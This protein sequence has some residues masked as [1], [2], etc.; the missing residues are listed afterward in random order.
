LKVVEQL[1]QA[2]RRLFASRHVALARRVHDLE[3]KLMHPI[4]IFRRDTIFGHSLVL[5]GPFQI[6][7]S[8]HD[9]RNT[10]VASWDVSTVTKDER[11]ELPHLLRGQCRI[12]SRR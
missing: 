4:P 12:Q 10:S 8:F 1:D 6:E 9:E 3:S 7:V 11:L 5:L 2:K